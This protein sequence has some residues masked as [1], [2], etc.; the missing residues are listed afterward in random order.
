MLPKGYNVR[1]AA[2]VAAFFAEKEGGDIS[3]LKLV[4]LIYLADRESLDK[5]D[6]PLLFD[7]FVSMPHG[8][9]NSITYNYISGCYESKEWNDF[10]VDKADH[11]VALNKKIS[12]KDLDELSDAEIN[13]LEEVWKKFGAMDKYKIRDYTHDSC[14]E[15]EDPNGSSEPIP[16]ERVFK[17]LRKDNVAMLSQAIEEERQLS[18]VW[19]C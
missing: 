9:V 19:E 8:P 4:K 6:Y 16:Y 1:K 12:A 7:Q 17:N 11:V 10:I 3:V 18:G 2:Q 5:Y 13:V 14:F 15:W